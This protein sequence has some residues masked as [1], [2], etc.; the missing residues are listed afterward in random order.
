MPT[1]A[2]RVCGSLADV[3]DAYRKLLAERERSGHEVDGAV[4]KVDD[5][6]LR[7][8]LGSRPKNPRWAVGWK[9]PAREENTEVREVEWQIGRTGKLT[10]VARLE[11]VP[12]G[13]V[14]V[15][16]A[17]LH[18]PA[19]I[20]ALDVRLGDTVVV[21][22]SGDVIPYVVKTIRERRPARAPKVAVPASCPSCGG[23]TERVG[24]ELYCANTLSCPG[25]LKG[26]IRHFASR[27]AMD[28]AGLG[29]EWIDQLVERRLL[30]SVADLY[31]LGKKDLVEKGG[32]GEKQADNLLQAL[33]RSKERT[34]ARFLYA[35]GIR[36]VGD[37]TAA[38]LADHFGSLAKIMSASEETLRNLPGVGSVAGRAV[39]DFFAD[40]R[41]RD[42]IERLKERG[43]ALK[44]PR[45]KSSRLSGEIVAFT[46]EL[47]SMTRDE[48]RALVLEHGGR[49]ADSVSSK[50]TLV[51]AGPGAGQ[52]LDKA[53]RLG[54]KTLDEREFL[55]R[56]GR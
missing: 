25:Q 12:I 6:K 36:H 11:P 32:M 14:T 2:V 22:R 15:R 5:L 1:N 20:E 41:N 8:E 44:E 46:G 4:V 34:L 28:I 54:L 3:G 10:P 33:E 43:L 24:P 53:R 16:N 31:A 26:A 47:E 21:T 37:L 18:N 45:R 42:V 23:K 40:R 7:A 51:V 50:V 19:R 48:A 9:F 27:G 35:L 49:A 30:A 13:G 52:K 39:F 17:S 56:V 55:K 29:P 38:A